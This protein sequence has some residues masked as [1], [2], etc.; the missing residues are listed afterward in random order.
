MYSSKNN[1]VLT[2]GQKKASLCSRDEAR[3]I[4][5]DIWDEY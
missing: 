5:K 3:M 4:A 2:S 1:S